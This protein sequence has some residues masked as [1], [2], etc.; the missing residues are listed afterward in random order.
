MVFLKCRLI[1]GKNIISL[2][3]LFSIVFLKCRVVAGK[4]IF[5]LWILFFYGF[6]HVQG[7]CRKKYN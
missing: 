2:W 3:R 5:N 6:P 1:A 4:Y 7:N